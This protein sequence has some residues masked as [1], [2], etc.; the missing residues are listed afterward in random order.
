MAKPVK[1]KLNVKLLRKIQAHI[2]EEPKRLNMLDWDKT[3]GDRPEDMKPPC[4]TVGCIAGWACHLTD[5]RPKTPNGFVRLVAEVLGLGLTDKYYYDF[6]HFSRGPAAKLFIPDRWP[7]R[8]KS[9]LDKLRREFT[10][11]AM[12]QKA[13][14][15]VKRID[16]FIKTGE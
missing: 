3:E 6:L 16:H 13:K 2:L 9:S 7:K 11:K 10:P 4:N 15:T 12:L 8:Y 14:I 1:Q 5:K